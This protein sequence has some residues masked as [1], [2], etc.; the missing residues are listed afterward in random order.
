MLDLS[1]TATSSSTHVST[2]CRIIFSNP[3]HPALA[4][5][6]PFMIDGQPIY[7][8]GNSLSSL[9]NC[10]PN[11]SAS[12][13]TIQVNFFTE[14]CETLV[15]TPIFGSSGSL[16]LRANGVHVTHAVLTI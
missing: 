6:W 14:S 7:L 13:S 2:C 5:T 10:S 12:S 8:A 16:H 3:Y 11:T 4:M 1:L 9:R 15:S